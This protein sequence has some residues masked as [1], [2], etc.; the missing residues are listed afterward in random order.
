MSYLEEK[1]EKEL[2]KNNAA[3]FYTYV[4]D[5]GIKATERLK[6]S[7]AKANTER[8]LSKTDYGISAQRLSDLGLGASG[9]EDY[10]K[11]QADKA[12]AKKEEG[13]R[14]TK[15]IND[16]RNKQGY[17]NY[18]SD[19]EALQ[20]KISQSVIE[21]IGSGTNFDIENAFAEAVRAGV[22]RELAYITAESGVTKAK[23]TV[24][25]QA[26]QFSKKNGFSAKK[27]HE[28]ALG[29]GLD[30]SYAKRVYDEISTLTDAEKSFYSGMSAEEYFDYI[31]SKFK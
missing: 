23:E 8:A 1:Y 15:K 13:A 6:D 24:M 21:K 26:I 20:S 25:Q 18:L 12:F 22:S 5:K 7:L 31:Q 19:Y 3:S 14:L 28:Y 11:S 30:E 2:N 16:Y 4:S 17:R 29:L 10:V 27:A 9:Y